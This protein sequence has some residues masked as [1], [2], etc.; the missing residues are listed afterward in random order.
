MGPPMACQAA[1]MPMASMAPSVVAPAQYFNMV[2]QNRDGVI[3]AQE[4]QA[5]AATMPGGAPD[6]MATFNAMDRNMDGVVT[7][8]EAQCAVPSEPMVGG[9]PQPCGQRFAGPAPVMQPQPQGYPMGPPMACQAAPV[10]MASMAPPVVAPAQYFN[11][12]D[13]NRDGVITAQEAQAAATMNPGGA[14]AAMATFNAM[15]RNM[16]GVVTMAETQSVVPSEP[17][18]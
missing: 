6:A 16:D 14:P 11:V 18:A 3:T 2:D 17:M 7:M 15:D 9:M 1:P 10:P 8:A 5:A 13:Q 12:V 4:A